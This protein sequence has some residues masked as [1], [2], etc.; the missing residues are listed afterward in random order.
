[1]YSRM[2][3]ELI[4]LAYE[5]IEAK[6]NTALCINF[7]IAEDS[8]SAI[9]IKGDYR[10]PAYQLVIY[11]KSN[12]VGVFIRDSIMPPDKTS[13]WFLLAR[14]D[15][16]WRSDGVDRFIYR[17]EKYIIHFQ[18]LADHPFRQVKIPRQLQEELSSITYGNTHPLFQRD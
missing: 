12:Y 7:S 9:N 2:L 6:H 3:S 1:M 4:C 17:V 11:G 15:S 10:Y 18:G 16:C 13:E 8:P 14:H 5:D